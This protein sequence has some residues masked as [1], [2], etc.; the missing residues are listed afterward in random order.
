MASVQCGK[1]ELAI[2]CN[3]IIRSIHK[4]RSRRLRRL[5][6]SRHR[7][8]LWAWK[9]FYRFLGF[10]KPARQTPT[11][12]YLHVRLNDELEIRYYAALQE[13]ICRNYL[14]ACKHSSFNMIDVNVE[15]MQYVFK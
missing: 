6:N 14:H 10:G 8:K 11:K 5:Y 1:Q 7:T 2:S 9:N 12:E 4:E 3:K 15:D 13:K